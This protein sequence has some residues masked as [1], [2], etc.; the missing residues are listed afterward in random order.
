MELRPGWRDEY[1]RFCPPRLVLVIVARFRLR[2]DRRRSMMLRVVTSDD[3]LCVVESLC[4]VVGLQKPNRH[5]YGYPTCF[6]YQ[7]IWNG[8]FVSCM[9]KTQ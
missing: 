6:R 3:S 4:R 2:V 5:M 1:M 8:K 9:N 7:G